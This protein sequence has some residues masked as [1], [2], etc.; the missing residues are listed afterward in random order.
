[1]WIY[2]IPI[3]IGF[4]IALFSDDIDRAF[5]GNKKFK[6]VINIF[7]VGIIAVCMIGAIASV[8]N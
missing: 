7:I 6:K 3:I 8:L 1:M 2:L 4:V 5:N